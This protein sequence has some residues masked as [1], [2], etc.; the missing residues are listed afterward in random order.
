MPN[1]YFLTKRRTSGSETQPSIEIVEACF[2]DHPPSEHVREEGFL[3]QSCNFAPA[4]YR[5]DINIVI[6]VPRVTSEDDLSIICVDEKYEEV[7]AQLEFLVNEGIS[8]IEDAE[9]F[10]KHMRTG[11]VSPTTIL[12]AW[13]SVV[14]VG[15]G[16]RLDLCCCAL[17]EPRFRDGVKVEGVPMV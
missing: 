14:K 11:N 8:K 10:P 12:T 4:P 5:R 15:F 13:V 3:Y 1:I 6:R 16:M 7:L 17:D 2:A 9:L